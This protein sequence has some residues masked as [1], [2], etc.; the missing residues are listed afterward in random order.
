MKRGAVVRDSIVMRHST[1]GE[2]TQVDKAIIAENVTIG[3]DVAIGVGEV[4]ALNVEKP[5]VY[6]FGLATIGEKTVVPS[7]VK[8]GK[9]TAISG[10]TTL[11]DYPNGEL[12]SGGVIAEK[13]G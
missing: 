13:D 4:E 6:A 9:N 2:N 11:E 7:G 12:P 3:K 10:V 5:Q 8:I 1:I